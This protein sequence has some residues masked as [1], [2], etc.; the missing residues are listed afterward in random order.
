M[1]LPQ[2]DVTDLADS[3]WETLASLRSGWRH[4]VG[5]RW[6]KQEEARE[7][8]PSLYVKFKKLKR[9]NLGLYDN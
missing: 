6:G 9:K 8:K 5:G 2:G 3:P 7:R 1:V 4:G